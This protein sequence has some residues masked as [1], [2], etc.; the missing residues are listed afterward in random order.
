MT[1]LLRQAPEDFIRAN[2]RLEVPPLVPEVKL[3][4]ASEVVPLWEATEAE[5]AEQGLPPPFWAFAWAGGQALARYLLDHPEVVRGKRVLDFAA[6]SGLQGIAAALAGA[7]AVEAVEIDAFACA[8]CHLNAAANGVAIAVREEDI[9]GVANPGW[10]V[11]LAGDICY[12]RPA[13]ERITAWLRGLVTQDCLV[14]MGDPG[15]TYLPREGL[16]R[17]IA[18]GVKTSRDLEDSDLRNAVV[19]RLAAGVS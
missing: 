18:Y 6:G 3:H 5:L 15:R 9:V 14:L 2:T 19:W 16:E 1:G 4:L 12:E 10:D 13:A 17:I 7:A 11:V 8:A